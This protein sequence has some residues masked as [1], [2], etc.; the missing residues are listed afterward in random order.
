MK[1][2]NVGIDICQIEKFDRFNYQDYIHFYHRVFSKEEIE[3]CHKFSNPNP[4]FAG[5]FAA[6]EAIFKALHPYYKIPIAWIIIN[7][8]AVGAPFVTFNDDYPMNDTLTKSLEVRVSISH[9]QSHSIACALVFKEGSSQIG[10]KI[11]QTISKGI[12]EYEH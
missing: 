12:N 5:I 1:D 2:W 7:H 11:I 9:T 10:D 3:Y 4:H 6:K 8:N